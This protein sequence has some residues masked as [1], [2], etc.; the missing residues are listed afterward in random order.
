[1]W[2]HLFLPIYLVG[3]MKTFRIDDQIKNGIVLAFAQLFH[4]E[5]KSEEI[6][7]QPTNKEFEGNY[8]FV[9][10]TFLKATKK[11]PE[12]SGKLIGDFLVNQTGL[13]DSYNVVKG[14][15]NL[16]IANKAWIAALKYIA[17]N[18][19]HGF[20]QPNGT[21]VMVEYSS[22]NTNK[23]L[24]LG[25]LRN[26][27][28]GYSVAKI[29]EANGYTVHKVQIINDRGIHICKSMLA[30]QKFGNGETP[31]SSGMKGDKLVGKYYVKFDQ[32]YREEVR[33][34]VSDGMSKEDAEKKA[35][36]MKEA[37]ELLKKWEDKEPEA[38]SLWEKMN[39]WVY[40]GFE[41]TYKTMGVEFDRLYYE[42]ETYLEGKKEV[43]KG[44][45]TGH[46]TRKEDGSVWVDLT[47]EGLDEKLLLRKDGT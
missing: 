31:E 22:P 43:L 5:I 26:N 13:I 9:V 45:E 34:L 38:Y 19:K 15:L 6:K 18:D 1:M 39:Q 3:K 35:S 10:F 33:E 42:S 37:Q 11:S 20:R 17:G 12:E 40:D 29:L 7:L 47:D 24:H 44:V 21:Q 25:H 30:W 23:P 4:T 2:H 36:I 14:F 46:F 8:T 28:L 32:I 16:V 41:K 27:F